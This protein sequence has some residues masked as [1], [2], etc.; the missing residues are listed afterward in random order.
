MALELAVFT[1]CAEG[2]AESNLTPGK[3]G[4]HALNMSQTRTK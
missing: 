4:L 3:Q 2:Q 1:L